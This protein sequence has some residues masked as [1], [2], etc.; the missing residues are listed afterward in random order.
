MCTYFFHCYTTWHGV[1]NCWP[2]NWTKLN[3]TVSNIKC[4]SI[5]FQIQTDMKWCPSKSTE[6]WYTACPI[7]CAK[8][9]L[10]SVPVTC[11]RLIWCIYMKCNTSK[12]WFVRRCVLCGYVLI[13]LP[14]SS[15]GI[16]TVPKYPCGC[17]SANQLNLK[18][19]VKSVIWIY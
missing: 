15:E 19:I 6:L 16:P 1:V 5:A 17:P 7:I 2:N 4:M 8:L 10:L 14:K 12:N 13:Y 9:C 3:T 11:C 18:N